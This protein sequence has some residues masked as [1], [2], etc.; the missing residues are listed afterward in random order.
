MPGLSSKG[1]PALKFPFKRALPLRRLPPALAPWL[2][3]S[4]RCFKQ[5]NTLCKKR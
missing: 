3:G 4:K 2:L 5:R 1:G